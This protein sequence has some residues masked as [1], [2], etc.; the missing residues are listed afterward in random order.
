MEKKS[1]HSK[2]KAYFWNTISSMLNAGMSALLLL[3]VNRICGTDKAGEFTLAFS[4]AQLMVTIGYFELRSYQVTDVKEKYS[5]SDYY[6]FKVLSCILMVFISVGYISIGGY[7]KDKAL[8]IAALCIFKMLDAYEDYFVTLY[9]S[10]NLL[11]IGAKISSIRQSFSMIV[12]VT[13]LVL[14]NNLMLSVVL[15]IIVSILIIFLLFQRK[16]VKK[17]N[18]NFCFNKQRIKEI[19]LECLPLFIG[20]YLILYVGNAPKYAIDKYMEARYQTYYGIIYL[21]SFVIN[22]LSGFVFKPLLTDLSNYYYTDKY[23]YK[24]II[25]KILV[26]LSIIFIMTFIVAYFIGI[27]VLEVM[28]NEKLSEYKFEFLIII[29]GGAITALGVIISY[30]ITIM[31]CQKWMMISYFLTAAAAFLFSPYFV[32]NFGI[33]GA[34]FGFLIYN[35]IKVTLF[36][37]ILLICS[38]NK[39]EEK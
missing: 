8:L 30:I 27:P 36:I 21:P 23:K 38:L 26:S 29:L 28:Y 3:V 2:S 24:I 17:Y 11:D 35:S 33:T 34:S 25:K 14:F 19:C 13:S 6:T 20:S 18:I 15:S 7:T 9:Q 10:Q 32:K 5:K 39:K 37:I 12:F 22:L 16:T 1:N 4:I 31:R